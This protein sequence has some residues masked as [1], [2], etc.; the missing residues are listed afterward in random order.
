VLDA[1][2][3]VV[4]QIFF[5]LGMFVGRFV[6]R[7]ANAPTRARQR[8]REQA[9]V[10]AFDVEETDLPEV[11]QLGVE[12]EPRVH[13]AA[14]HVVGQ[15]IEIVKANPFRLGIALPDPIEFRVIG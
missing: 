10:L 2:A 8:P 3:F 6:D 13:V 11:E 5:D 14:L 12:R 7:D 4:P 1:L 9:G 15:M